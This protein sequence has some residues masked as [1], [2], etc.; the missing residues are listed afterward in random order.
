MRLYLENGSILAG[1]G[2]P[3]NFLTHGVGCPIG[4]TICDQEQQTPQFRVWT[5]ALNA[6][7]TSEHLSVFR[8]RGASG[9]RPCGFLMPPLQTEAGVSLAATNI[10]DRTAAL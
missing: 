4:G 7:W 8:V 2:L 6:P 3:Q 9:E 10:T 5:E 1:E